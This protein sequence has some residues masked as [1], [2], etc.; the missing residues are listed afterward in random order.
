MHTAK[1]SLVFQNMIGG[2]VVEETPS[3]SSDWKSETQDRM[4]HYLR[5]TLKLGSS[6]PMEYDSGSGGQQGWVSNDRHEND[7]HIL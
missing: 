6:N 1:Q 2:E 7:L 5:E 3:P 4:L